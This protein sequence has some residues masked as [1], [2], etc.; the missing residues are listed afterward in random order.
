MFELVDINNFY[1]YLRNSDY[2]EVM[3]IKK[4]LF[5][6]LIFTTYSKIIEI[7]EMGE[8]SMITHFIS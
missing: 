2:A 3:C 6:I 1:E 5:K 7:G 4:R 8:I